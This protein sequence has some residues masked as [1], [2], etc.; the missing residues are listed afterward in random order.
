[1]A[2]LGGAVASAVGRRICAS[3][4]TVDRSKSAFVSARCRHFE[5][6]NVTRPSM[7]KRRWATL[8]RVARAPP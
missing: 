7:R 5:R 8:T 6:W 1:M 3:L 2:R 4:A